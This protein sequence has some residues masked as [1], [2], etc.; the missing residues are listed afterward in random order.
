[1]G[2]VQF[3][4]NPD[5]DEI[6]V[7]HRIEVPTSK[8]EFKPISQEMQEK[9]KQVFPELNVPLF[10]KGEGSRGSQEFIGNMRAKLVAKRK[11]R[12]PYKE[13]LLLTVGVTGLKK[14]YERRDIDNIL[15]SVFDAFKGIVFEDDNQIEITIAFKQIVPQDIVGLMIGLKIIDN[16]VIDKYVP[17]LFSDNHEHWGQAFID[18]FTKPTDEEFS[19]FEFY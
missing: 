6:F 12:W 17:T 16:T 14:F 10:K 1:M 18:R 4:Q 8:K 19:S 3:F 2:T 11:K 7:F 15:K 9:I 13:K 5:I